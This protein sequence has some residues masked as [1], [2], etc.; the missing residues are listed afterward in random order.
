M[1]KTKHVIIGIVMGVLLLVVLEGKCDWSISY[2]TDLGLAMVFGIEGYFSYK[3]FSKKERK[4]RERYYECLAIFNAF[5]LTY[6][7]FVYRSLYLDGN[8]FVKGRPGSDGVMLIGVFL[9]A[10]FVF[11]ISKYF[12]EKVLTK[13]W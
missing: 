11:P 7:L 1:K 3:Y 9:E 4:N 13:R 10:A 5:I 6:V 8:V 12:L 2:F